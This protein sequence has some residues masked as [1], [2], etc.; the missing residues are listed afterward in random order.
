MTL[1]TTL[2][3]AL[4][5]NQLMDISYLR[6]HDMQHAHGFGQYT[7][8]CILCVCVCVCV[9]IFFQLMVAVFMSEVIS[10]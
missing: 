5:G 9:I 1:A 4:I 10:K 6:T 7:S 2:I 8:T 3:A